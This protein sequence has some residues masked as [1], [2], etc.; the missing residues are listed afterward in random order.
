MQ[1]DERAGNRNKL[2]L[3]GSGRG[4][5]PGSGGG[6]QG[7]EQGPGL[8]YVL[9]LVLEV[10]D[11]SLTVR[12]GQ[13]LWAVG[14]GLNSAPVCVLGLIG[15]LKRRNVTK[16]GSVLS[17]VCTRCCPRTQQRVFASNTNYITPPLSMDIP[18]SRILTNKLLLFIIYPV[19]DT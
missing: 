5:K 8:W 7:S 1:V 6:A 17:L 15:C 9:V 10:V 11:I 14:G 3:T 4:I 19:L 13:A 2:Q 16:S 18:T 12:R